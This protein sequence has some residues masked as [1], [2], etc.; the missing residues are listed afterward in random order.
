MNWKEKLSSLGMQEADLSVRIKKDIQAYNDLEN[1]LTEVK[2]ELRGDVSEDEKNELNESL[3]EIQNGI[4]VMNET[5]I[6]SIERFYKNKDGYAERAK[7]LKGG[8]TAVKTAEVGGVT[9]T[10]PHPQPVVAS[11]NGQSATQEK[12]GGIGKWLLIGALAL[13]GGG[14]ALNY[15]NSND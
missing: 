7:N 3:N 11:A 13:I 6:K 12:K 14:V 8:K 5:L 10:K 1:G 4:E 15:M 2:K 9:V